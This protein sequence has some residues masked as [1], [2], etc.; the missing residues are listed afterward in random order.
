MSARPDARPRPAD[1]L[2][3]NPRPRPTRDA[4]VPDEVLH[5]RRA[6]IAL[7]FVTGI[8]V[9]TWLS[10]LPSIKHMLDLSAAELGSV[11]VVG[12]VGS[13]AMVLAA[14]ALT[15]R[16]GS[17]NGLV[18]GAVMFSFANVLV[19]LGPTI[20]STLVLAV[21]ILISSSSYAVAN[22]PLN[23]ESV[24][25]ERG[26]GRSV[27]PQF[28]A[29]FSIG[30]VTGS[31][32]GAAA[33]W[34]GVPVF[35][36]FLA[37]S[38]GTL[39][40]RVVV[41]PR[42]VLPVPAELAAAAAGSGPGGGMRTALGAWR[43]RRTLVI[44]VIVMTGIL[45]EGSANN[46]LTVAVVEGFEQ[47][48]AMAAIVFGV[49]T[50]AM[51]LARLVGTRVIDRYGRVAVLVASSASSL[52]G[53]L[54]FSLGPSL[55]TA[56]VGAVGWGL[57]AGLVFPIGV[58]AVSGDRLRMAGRV[59]VLS[60][61]GSTASIVAPPLLGAA[62]E[63]MGVRHALVLI[64]GGFVVAILLART[65]GADATEPAEPDAQ[66]PHAMP[67]SATEL[68]AVAMVASIDLESDALGVGAAPVAPELVR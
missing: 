40:F 17:R 18:I 20:G 6:L 62:A 12:S 50:G 51:T 33:S 64:V 59:S 9:A 67:T 46:W 2:H 15:N 14:G 53:L 38:L 31:L 11:L 30:S 49:F 22:V 10:R 43:E 60:T 52:V 24:V 42:A 34:A 25:I 63:T 36:H 58:A 32:L 65:V 39:V 28:H 8:A 13:L 23:L 66:E 41:V 61:F 19:G 44:G 37:L 5:A 26:M 21:G 4:A 55:T 3:P 16:W 35:A 1:R 27:V 68:A 29:A 56:V 48:E 54:L 57:G 47:T 45:S 7:Y